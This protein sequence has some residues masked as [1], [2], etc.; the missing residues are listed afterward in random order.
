MS[1]GRFE[2]GAARLAAMAALH[3]GA[4]AVTLCGEAEALAIHAAHATALMLREAADA[5][6]LAA[7]IAG[8]R[9]KA[10]VIGPAAGVNA[11][12]RARVE[13]VLASGHP[14]VLDAD[15]LTLLAGSVVMLARR[16]NPASPLVLYAA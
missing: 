11:A 1:G 13:A 12:T 7:L 9:F 5:Q 6:S 16:T 3:A 4:G 8:G 10:I 15:A 14:A 2:T